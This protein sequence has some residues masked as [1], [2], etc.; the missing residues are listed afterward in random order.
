MKVLFVSSGNSKYGISPIILSQGKSLIEVGITVDFFGI[1]GKGPLGYI[2]NIL[3]LRRILKSQN[4][5]LIHSHY[6]FSGIVAVLARTKE[7]VVISFM[8]NDI[9]LSG[10]YSLLNKLKYK[11]EILLNRFFSRF[12]F[13]FVIVKS[14]EMFDKLPGIKKKSIIPNGVNLDLFSPIPKKE[15]RNVLGLD[16]KKK[17]VLFGSD[18]NRLEKNFSLAEKSV[19][20]NNVLDIHMIALKGIE[21]QYLKNYYSAADVLLLTS[22][23]EGSPNVIKEAMACSCP[24][25]STDV[26]DVRKLLDG[27]DGC[28]ISSFDPSDVADKISKTLAFEGRTNGRQKL[29]DMGLDQKRVALKLISIYNELIK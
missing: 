11:A 18:P 14:Q 2:K 25:V 19:R 28:F 9:F 12:L 5:Q 3:P 22:F 10:D 16:H 24:V 15:A 21:Q 7:K 20:I 23:Q 6:G 13:D 26:G 17:V 1:K 29:I 4:Y 8:G 27:V